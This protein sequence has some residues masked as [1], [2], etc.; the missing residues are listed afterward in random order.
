MIRYRTIVADPLC[1]ATCVTLRQTDFGPSQR[2]HPDRIADLH[3]RTWEKV[4][5]LPARYGLCP[6]SWTAVVERGARPT[7][8]PTSTEG[9]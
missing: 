5:G 1:A 9:D 6:G 4:C 2:L 7:L 8:P 3:P